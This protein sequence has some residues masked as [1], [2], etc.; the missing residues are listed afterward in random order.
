MG[1]LDDAHDISTVKVPEFPSLLSKDPSK[2]LRFVPPRT[3][4]PFQSKSLVLKQTDPTRLDKI[5]QRAMSLFSSFVFDEWEK[6]KPRL[7]EEGKAFVAAY[8][9]ALGAEE[10]HEVRHDLRPNRRFSGDG[11][12][13]RNRYYSLCRSADG[14][15]GGTMK[16]E[17]IAYNHPWTDGI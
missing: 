10:V 17:L 14:S 11:F 7:E 4:P 15:D 1:P 2:P 12:L 16:R 6:S 8:A 13:S 5:G 3:P 9:A